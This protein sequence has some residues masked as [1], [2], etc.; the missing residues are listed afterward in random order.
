MATKS[1]K[2]ITLV[3]AGDDGGPHDAGGNRGGAR[4]I[5]RRAGGGEA[6]GGCRLAK[7]RAPAEAAAGDRRGC[8]AEKYPHDRADWRWKNGNRAEAGAPGGVPVRQSRG[9]QI[10]GG[11]IRWAG[12]GID[13]ARSGRD[14]HRYGARRKTRRSSRPG[15]TIRRGADF[16]LAVASATLACAGDARE[17][18]GGAARADA[19]D[20]RE[21]KDA[22]AR[23]ETGP[24]DG[25]PRSAGTR[26]AII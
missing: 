22:I 6:R 25:G 4:Q 8:A 24:A 13:G 15:R 5:H 17:R 10:H 19:A 23:G 7:P 1:E 9:L 20:A 2:E 11:R 12:R 26:H 21:A 16:G 14:L 18:N 3:P